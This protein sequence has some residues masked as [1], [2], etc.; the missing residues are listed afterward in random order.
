MAQ[1]LP[2]MVD[3]FKRNIEANPGV[4]PDL[5]Q[6][7][8]PGA[9]A[10]EQ[11]LTSG[12]AQQQSEIEKTLEDAA[13]FAADNARSFIWVTDKQAAQLDSQRDTRDDWHTWLPAELA[14]NFDSA[15]DQQPA[16]Q[17]GKTLDRIISDLTG[18]PVDKLE[19]AA[20]Q[21]GEFI[22]TLVG[23]VVEEF[24]DE[25]DPDIA[26]A[27]SLFTPEELEEI[28]MEALAESKL[29]DSLEEEGAQS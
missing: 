16:D 17:L 2:M 8:G 13:S 7:F 21:I 26:K 29:P 3:I 19:D 20:D 9:D 5:A 18:I 14:K 12:L 24:L 6:L 10:G 15:W 22:E 28:W 4:V 27:A 23:A 25:D 11:Q 1:A